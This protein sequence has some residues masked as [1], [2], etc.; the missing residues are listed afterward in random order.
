MGFEPCKMEPDIWLKHC[1]EYHEHIDVCV[2]DLLIASKDTQGVVDSL[3]NKHDL[4]IK[5][6]GP[7]SY[8]LGRDFGRD[9]NE[10]CTS[11]LGNTLKR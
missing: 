6:K 3:T 11:V 7:M 8:H 1:G 9:G 5:G 4:K 10:K 2:D